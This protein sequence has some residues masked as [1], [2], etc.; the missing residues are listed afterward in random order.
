MNLKLKSIQTTFII[1]IVALT[2]LSVVGLGAILYA[3]NAIELRQNVSTTKI[4]E[5]TRNYP[6]VEEYINSQKHAE[7]HF[8]KLASLV[9]S[10]QS[11][12]LARALIFTGVPTLLISGLLAYALAR[13][14]VRP[15]EE[16][17]A[18]Q[19]RFLQDASHE[20]RNP[21]AALYAVIQQAQTSE[22]PAD[23]K[24]SLTTLERQ[25][26]QLVRLNEDLLMLERTKTNARKAIKH[27]ISELTLDVIDSEYAQAASKGLEIRSKIE[28]DVMLTIADADWICLVRNLV[29]NAIKYAGKSKKIEVQLRTDRQRVHLSVKDSGI[30]IPAEA[31]AQIGE[32]FYRAPNVG[33]IEGT[34]IGMAIVRQ[35]VTTYNGFLHIDS[36]PNRGTKVTISFAAR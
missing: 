22:K 30:G 18:A 4:H 19:E 5:L 12:L 27:N 32:R 36:K 17:F 25:A 34:G 35:V 15:V 16:T 24:R 7:P 33:R 2:T 28:T 10:D 11:N 21:L 20:M 1:S 23:V 26:R 29:E 6:A 13:K 31:L 3:T 14:L 9:K 8:I